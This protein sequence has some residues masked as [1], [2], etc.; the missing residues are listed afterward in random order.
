MCYFTKEEK[1]KYSLDLNLVQDNKMFWKTISP[2]FVNNLKNASKITVGKKGNTLSE[3]EKI[4]ETFNKFFGNI[5][6]NLKL[7]SAIFY[8]NFIFHQMITP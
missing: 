8:Q 6:K 7:V 1:S 2:Y 3:N 5:I 4:A